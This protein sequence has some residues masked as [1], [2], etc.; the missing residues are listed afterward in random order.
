MHIV[1]H[2]GAHCTDNERLLRCLLRDASMLAEHNV[3]VPGQGRYRKLFR[4]TLEGLGEAE[5]KE[6]TRDL[7]LDAVLD[8][9]IAERL[10][11]SNPSFLC[12]PNRVFE[13]GQLYAMAG[14]R[15]KALGQIFAG[16]EI[17]IFLGLRNPASFIPDVYAQS[18][19]M[20]FLD[21]MGG[22]DPRQVRWSDLVA[23]LHEAL[24]RAQ[25]VLWANEDTP[26]IWGDILRRMA[27]TPDAAFAGE[28][29]LMET[30]MTEDG[31]GRFRTY[32]AQRNITGTAQRRRVI[33]AFL[34]KYAVEEEVVEEVDL[35]GIDNALAAE[36]TS[37]YEADCTK[38]AAMPGVD[39]IAP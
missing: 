36:L 19:G 37:A 16:D 10:V 11:L 18:S 13:E 7:L 12:P 38:I 2:I 31:M 20:A 27:G 34:D 39:W 35:P 30:I 14:T 17:T 26:L 21:F 6:G 9:R 23:R 28:Y 24:P 25:L 33:A 4:D 8:G 3:A 1:F 5:P 15:A 32:L 22:T 29:D